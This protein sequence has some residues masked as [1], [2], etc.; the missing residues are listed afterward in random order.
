MIPEENQYTREELIEKV[1]ELTHRFQEMAEQRAK[2]AGVEA[3]VSRPAIVG[4]ELF[5][6]TDVGDVRVL[7]YGL[8]DPDKLPLFVNIHGGGF[9]FGAPEAEDPFMMNIAKNAGVKILSVGYSL[10]PQAMFP[11][12][13]NE[14]Y[15]V[16][17][18]AQSHPDE[19]GIDPEKI[20]VG[21]HSAG[22]NLTASLCLKNAETSVLDIKCSIL[23]YPL[24]DIYTD[25]FLKPQVPDNEM[26]DYMSPEITHIFDPSYCN[27]KEERKNP[28]VSPVFASAEQ[29]SA[30][31]PTLLITAGLDALRR[32]GDIF[33]DK[34]VEAGVDV[35]YKCFEDSPHGF[36]LLGDRPDAREAWGMMISHLTR[37]LGAGKNIG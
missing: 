36:T 1:G 17:E 7:T 32:E 5:L 10:A 6:K 35:T 31:P 30:F 20:A 22:G 24:V 27:D 16:V 37:W 26:S 11:V 34:L 13:V 18:Y 3:P 9:V 12:A 23:A 4:N 14:C 19:F 29:L 33:R 25:A 21:G 15:A 28:L 2:K 8:D